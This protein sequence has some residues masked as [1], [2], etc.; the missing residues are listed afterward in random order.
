[1]PGATSMPWWRQT[2]VVFDIA[3]GVGIFAATIWAARELRTSAAAAGP[4]PP[5]PRR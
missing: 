1:V 3:C 5:W 2:H 4:A